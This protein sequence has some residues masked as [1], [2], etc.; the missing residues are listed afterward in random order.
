MPLPV[1]VGEISL[2]E[3]IVDALQCRQGGI[4]LHPDQVEVLAQFDAADIVE[5][6]RMLGSHWPAWRSYVL[7]NSV[8]RSSLAEK[9]PL[10]VPLDQQPLEIRLAGALQRRQGGLKLYPDQVKLLARF[11]AADIAEKER[12]LTPRLWAAWK[13]I[14]CR[15]I[16]S[17]S[18]RLPGALFP[19][20]LGRFCVSPCILLLV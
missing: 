10:P 14:V 18:D 20:F 4:K 3:Q 13:P 19:R 7:A 15:L 6:E 17:P 11:D 2:E 8:P 12:M 1:L 9:L 5:K 16:I